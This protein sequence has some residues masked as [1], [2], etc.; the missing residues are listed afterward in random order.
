MS[1]S[2]VLLSPTLY[3]SSTSSASVSV[4]T[5]L[6]TLNTARAGSVKIEDTA[7]NIALNLDALQKFNARISSLALSGNASTLSITAKQVSKDA[8]VLSKLS[9]YSLAVQNALAADVS[10][11]ASNAKV[12]SIAVAD[13]VKNISANF[14][15]LSATA[16]VSSL[17]Q[18]GPIAPIKLTSAQLQDP[19]KAALL[20]K[21]VNSYTLKVTGV[22]TANMATVAANPKVAAIHIT[23][24][25]A[26]IA[27]HL[28]DLRLLGIR[29]ASAKATDKEA[30]SVTATQ[31]KTDALV[32][33]KIYGGYELAVRA[34]AFADVADLNKNKKVKAIDVVDASANIVHNLPTLQKLGAHLT[35]VT[36]TDAQTP[37]ALNY[38]QFIKNADVLA[39]ISN[40]DVSYA[41]TQV[42]YANV[43]ALSANAKVASIGV[44]DTSV[45]LS[46][47]ID[48]LTLLDSKL[49]SVTRTGAATPLSLTAEQLVNNAAVLDKFK[50]GYTVSVS[51]VTAA[52]AAALAQLS[53][54]ASFSVS[55]SNAHIAQQWDALNAAGAKLQRINPTGVVA[56]MSIA[57]TQLSQSTATLSKIS[58]AYSL[59]VT[60]AKADNAAS[61]AA[62][63]TVASLKVSDT[64]ERISAKL[65]TL[66]ALGGKLTEIA[67]SDASVPL[68]LTAAQRVANQD[69]LAKVSTDYS[70]VVSQVFASE[71]V[72]TAAADRVASIAVADTSANISHNLDAL[73]GL[74]DK[75]TQ[76]TQRG[77]PSPLALTVS[78]LASDTEVL[79]KLS[80]SFTLLVNEVSVADAQRVAATAHVSAFNV[81]DTS[82]N[83]ASGLGT[84]KDFGQAL[85][86]ITQSSVAPLQISANVLAANLDVLKKISNDFSL[87]VSD[88]TA[89]TAATVLKQRNVT[90]ISVTDTSAHIAAKIDTL[91][92]FNTRITSLTQSGTPETLHLTADQYLANQTLLAK[93]DAGDY[94][95]AVD[96]VRASQVATLAADTHVKTLNVSD[97]AVNVAAHLADLQAAMQVSQAGA[98]VDKLQAIQQL[99]KGAVAVT[100]SQLSTY[101]DVLAKFSN[102]YSLAVSEVLA[103]SA[104]AVATADH[105]VSVAVADTSAHIAANLDAMT[106]L[107]KELVRVSQTGTPSALSL[108]ASQLLADKATL[109]KIT[110]NYTVALQGVS[111]DA[112]AGLAA[113]GHVVAMDVVDT[114]ANI[115]R[116]LDSL[117]TI[118]AKLH[119]ITQTDADTALEINAQQYSLDGA[120]LSKVVGD[121][122]LH[123]SGVS[124]AQAAEVAHDAHVTSYSVADTAAHLSHD[125]DALVG[126]AEKLDH[127]NVTG[128]V[129]PLTLSATQLSDDASVLAKI[130]NNYNLSVT[131]VL[132]ADASRIASTQHVTSVAVAD[133]SAHVAA[134]LDTLQ[135]LGG[136]LGGI[137]QTGTAQALVMTEQAYLADQ[138]ALS[139]IQDSYT[140]AL[141]GVH[142]D[143]AAA[144]GADG[145]VAAL[146]VVDSTLNIQR[147]IDDLQSLG[148]HLVDVTQTDITAPLV[149]SETQW[150]SDTAALSKIQGDYVLHV[151]DVLANDA[152]T[153]AAQAHVASVKVSDT[154]EHVALHLDEL[155]ALGDELAA[156]ALQG[157]DKTLDITAGQ[158]QTDADVIGKISTAYNVHVSN[159]TA[160]E[161]TALSSNVHVSGVTVSDTSAHIAAQLDALQAMGKKLSSID[162]SGTAA[163][164]SIT[165]EQFVTDAAALAKISDIYTLHVT[166]VT[167]AN[168]T[169]VAAQSNVV[170]LDVADSTANLAKNIDALNQLNTK[171]GTITQTGTA[172]DWVITASQLATSEATFSKVQGDLGLDVRGVMASQ[173][174]A[175]SAHAYVNALT[176]KDSTDNI[177]A[178]WSS[179]VQTSEIT[180]ITTTGSA[181][182]AINAT[183]WTDGAATIAKINSNYTMTV[184][185]VLAADAS[186]IA[187]GHVSSVSVTDTS[188]NIQTHLQALQTLGDQVT[189][190]TQTTVTP[191][192]LTADTLYATAATLAKFTNGYTL[193]VSQVAAQDAATVAELTG[194]VSLSVSDTSANLATALDDLQQLGA[195]VS[196]ITV[197]DATQALQISADQWA[198]DA[199]TLAKMESY[200]LS[201]ADV[202]MQALASVQAD[203]HVVHMTVAD[204]SAHLSQ[205]FD[206]LVALGDRLSSVTQVTSTDALSLTATQLELGASVLSKL[207]N[208][209]SLSVRDVSAAHASTVAQTAHVSSVSV[210]DSS[211][212]VA[213]HITALDALDTQLQSI[214]Q[215]GVS[216]ELSLS[217]SDWAATSGVWDKFTNDVSVALTGVSASDAVGTASHAE[218]AHLSVSDTR[219]NVATHWDELL[220][221]QTS[222]L[223]VSLT[224]ADAPMTLSHAQVLAGTSLFDKL[225]GTYALNVTEV[226]AHNAATLANDAHVAAMDI[227]DSALNVANVIDQLNGLDKLTSI[228]LSDSS[229]L[230]LTAAQIAA[231]PAAIAKLASSFSVLEITD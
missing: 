199:A 218:V 12:T 130:A 155:H 105:V 128:S 166:G 94:T 70:L 63:A 90:S 176:V 20:N 74:G 101:G 36:L 181:P 146:H 187:T 207:S 165:A 34:A 72:A 44:A 86:S 109:A 49:A 3:A 200:Q 8:Q 217:A 62:K 107:G 41:V 104:S 171:L 95:L 113:N 19:T 152:T 97:T 83:I 76:V 98:D 28:D 159:M 158:W 87:T 131:D 111:A 32:L 182:I 196:A 9:G 156:V 208:A 204:T 112:A 120:A 219:E 123:V 140:L 143:Q 48:D 188:A 183:Q 102:N 145:H 110:N 33:G 149:I 228:S 1:V 52:N 2:S 51:G 25:S 91:A 119:T 55:D 151:Q 211:A 26:Q 226:Q 170:S 134:G 161:A 178:N 60:D 65:D 195:T 185:D 56:P 11:L 153:V 168:A 209:Y 68:T 22:S 18:T 88:V 224:G 59:N 116:K 174:A 173:A 31:V 78:Q 96:Q 163:I 225:D 136:K 210:A 201:V 148:E 193:S 169:Q 53:T 127:I 180:A 216:A 73:Q 66:Q 212:N 39:K 45:N 139:K 64:S 89:E 61:I 103:A 150:L 93:I 5:A 75:L 106:A 54:V 192:A 50:S 125:L 77:T 154:A 133:T 24:S 206:A 172:A 29:L 126:I 108:S 82:A 17:T 117:Q 129:A 85:N 177:G 81:T 118:Q 42:S 35:S 229:T 46:A 99:G 58:T 222:L 15:V 231:N 160:Q 71:A 6:E 190:I 230:E 175:V 223:A 69:A 141:E 100:Q 197:S 135:A 40:T 167:A 138:G 14:D 137:Q 92:Q 189:G 198:R 202:S 27:A 114:S 124:T 84:L 43:S 227:V 21:V 80:N 184:S 57:A 132:V 215:T 213:L 30:L 4:A 164:L 37:V 186:S 23:D 67:Q 147:H 179:L 122:T 115:A 221:L 194:L 38:S 16:K 142:A 79:G 7:E 13:T 162:Q 214:T 205:D 191:L 157:V 220:G 203:D 47:H 121:F 144:I 10:V